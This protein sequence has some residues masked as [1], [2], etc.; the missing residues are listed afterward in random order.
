MALLAT[1][2]NGALHGG[3]SAEVIHTLMRTPRHRV[4]G[5]F[6]MALMHVATMAITFPLCI[7]VGCLLGW[8]VHI[9]L[10]VRHLL[11]L[12]TSGITPNLS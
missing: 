4:R 2:T 6:W 1:R 12:L 8:H 7:G 10:Q 5:V 3:G 9:V 11:T